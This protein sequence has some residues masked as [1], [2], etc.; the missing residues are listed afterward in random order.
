[1]ANI[2][3]REKLTFNIVF[4]ICQL[5]THQNNTG[6]LRNSDETRDS[7]QKLSLHYSP[8]L[9]VKRTSIMSLDNPIARS[10]MFLSFH[11]SFASTILRKSQVPVNK[12]IIWKTSI[13][14]QTIIGRVICHKGFL[15]LS[16]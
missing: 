1:M 14:F 6:A 7:P 3:V 12:Y 15:N 9:F 5:I 16:S 10:K 13:L 11:A 2:I 4:G 8:L